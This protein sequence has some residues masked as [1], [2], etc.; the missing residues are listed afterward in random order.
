MD[1]LQVFIHQGD[2]SLQAD[3]NI[4][5][6]LY[7]AP[8]LRAISTYNSLYNHANPMPS[9]LTHLHLQC[10]LDILPQLQLPLLKYLHLSMECR[11]RWEVYSQSTPFSFSS[12]ALPVLVTLRLNGEI[13]E[14]E[15]ELVRELVLKC[16]R[17]VVN[18][19]LDLAILEP[20]SLFGAKGAPLSVVYPVLHLCPHLTVLGLFMSHL[21]QRAPIPPLPAS[22]HYLR[23]LDHSQPSARSLSLL[24]LGISG[25]SEINYN[26][27][28]AFEEN[29]TNSGVLGV[30][31]R[32]EGESTSWSLER[33]IIPYT[34]SDLGAI[35]AERRQN[36]MQDSREPVASHLYD[37]AE[38]AWVLLSHFI[39][40]K[41]P[42]FDA[43]GI[44]LHDEKGEGMV[45]FN[46]FM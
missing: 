36:G 46:P 35:W 45:I 12:W 17:T 2:R 3:P 30:F 28:E 37:P 16:S 7:H 9:A 29:L 33:V 21:M 43:E 19:V 31:G 14:E 38:Q 24:I 11:P 1:R 10:T 34:W 26:N 40:K 41:L 8:L 4:L 27:R 22:S 23:S 32:S 6:A 44:E 13:S 5:T 25:F 39:G 18:L 15:G 42:V 20:G